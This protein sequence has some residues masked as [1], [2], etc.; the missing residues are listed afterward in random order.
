MAVAHFDLVASIFG[1]KFG[2]TSTLSA[3]VCTLVGLAAIYRATSLSRMQA[4]EANR[5]AWDMEQL[6]ARRTAQTSV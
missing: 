3:V 5:F 2:S 1:M 6:S 4:V